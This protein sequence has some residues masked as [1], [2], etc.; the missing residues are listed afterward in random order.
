VVKT[1]TI[2]ADIYGADWYKCKPNVRCR[3]FMIELTQ[4]ADGEDVE[5]RRMEVE[6]E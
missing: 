1:I 4:P 6:F 3:Y 5:I 2:P